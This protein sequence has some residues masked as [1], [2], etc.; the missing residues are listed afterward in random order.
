MYGEGEW[1]SRG[2][3]TYL[4]WFN[5]AESMSFTVDEDGRIEKIG[6]HVVLFG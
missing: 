6:L 1:S 4:Y 3:E 2:D 5:E